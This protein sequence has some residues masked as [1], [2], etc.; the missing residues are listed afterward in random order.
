MLHIHYKKFAT[1]YTDTLRA[2]GRRK[3]ARAFWEYSFDVEER[4]FNSVGFY[5]KSWEVSKSTAHGW[6]QDFKKEY[7]LFTAAMELVNNQKYSSVEKQSERKPNDSRTEKSPTAPTTSAVVEDDKTIA[8]RQTNKALNKYND[9]NACANDRLFTDLFNIYNLNT[10]FPGSREKAKEE[11][12]KMTH[13]IKHEDLIRS[14]VLYLHD[15]KR[16]GKL[17]NLANFIKNEV[18][19]NYMPKYIRV[20]TKGGWIQGEYNREDEVFTGEDGMKMKVLSEV[21]TSKFIKGEIEFI[22]ELTV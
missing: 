14:S 18:Y 1:D 20:F 4:D 15:P 22:R 5:A 10:K 7:E 17:N 6:L 9:N 21:F 11:Y 16:E 19:I 13:N 3:K 8:E 12:F 2:K